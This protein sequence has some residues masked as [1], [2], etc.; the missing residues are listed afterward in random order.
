MLDIQSPKPY[1]FWA[2]LFY[3]VKLLVIA[4]QKKRMVKA[5]PFFVL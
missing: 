5:I 3:Y 2:L 4:M 1:R